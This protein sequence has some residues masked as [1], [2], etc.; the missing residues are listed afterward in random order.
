MLLI[1]ALEGDAV[2]NTASFF[3]FMGVSLSLVLASNFFSVLYKD[4]GAAY[5]TAR[6]GSGLLILKLN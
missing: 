6:A 3:G 4:V 2:V 1:S 5:G